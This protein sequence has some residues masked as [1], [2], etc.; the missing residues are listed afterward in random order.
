MMC[1]AGVPVINFTCE[2]WTSPNN[3]GIFAVTG[4][5]IDKV[6]FECE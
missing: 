6:P 1:D 5:W 4:Q 3:F 2:V